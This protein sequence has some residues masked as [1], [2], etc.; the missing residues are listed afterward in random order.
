M[1]DKSEIVNIEAVWCFQTE[2]SVILEAVRKI[3][4]IESMMTLKHDGSILFKFYE[5]LPEVNRTLKFSYF[6]GIFYYNE[7]YKLIFVDN[8]KPIKI[9][10]F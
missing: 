9:G 8:V 2:D 1:D 10:R 3:T 6:L 4:R 5:N 7:N